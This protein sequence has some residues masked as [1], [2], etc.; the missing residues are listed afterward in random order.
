MKR[1]V[2][3]DLSA[4]QELISHLT[5][6]SA[7]VEEAAMGVNE[8]IATLNEKISAYNNTLKNV[9]DFRDDL[10]QR[11]QDHYDG[12]PEKWQGSD[13]GSNYQDWMDSWGSTDFDDL[14]VLEPIDPLEPGDAHEL[15]ELDDSVP[16]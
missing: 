11:M 10:V 15:A 7:E 14:A 2:E 4:R 5:Q 12:K 1:L 16:E 8:K 6:E 9:R 13:E 3:K